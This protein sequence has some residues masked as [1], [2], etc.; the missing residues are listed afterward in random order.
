MPSMI[1]KSYVTS[2]ATMNVSIKD[3]IEK[4]ITSSIPRRS[5]S[6]FEMRKF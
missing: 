1:L 2:E 6:V 5:V 3:E 4:V